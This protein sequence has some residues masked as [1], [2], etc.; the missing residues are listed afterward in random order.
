MKSLVFFKWNENEF[1]FNYEGM[2]P[3]EVLG[4][5]EWL[6]QHVI[7]ETKREIFLTERKQR[8]ENQAS[9]SVQ[10]G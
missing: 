7:E 3:I 2:T 4:M 8:R 9:D 5:L 10:F 1:D 6:K